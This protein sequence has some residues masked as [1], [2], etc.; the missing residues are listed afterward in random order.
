M[1]PIC[2]NI[3][4]KLFIALAVVMRS[5]AALFWLDAAIRYNSRERLA[6]RAT[7]GSIASSTAIMVK[8]PKPG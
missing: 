3:E 6:Q 7:A 8:F 2:F 1:V 4:A 5:L